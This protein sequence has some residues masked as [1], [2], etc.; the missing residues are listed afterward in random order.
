MGRA[1]LCSLFERE[2]GMAERHT[3]WVAVSKAANEFAD[4]YNAAA[5][6]TWTDEQKEQIVKLFNFVV[7]MGHAVHD[8]H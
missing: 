5:R 4:S 3:A 2:K 6:D 1:H 7:A 8:Y